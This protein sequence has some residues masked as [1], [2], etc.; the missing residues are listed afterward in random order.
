ML[1]SKLNNLKSKDKEENNFE[2]Q[3]KKE[4]NINNNTNIK[5]NEL[6]EISYEKFDENILQE[7]KKQQMEF[8]NDQNKYINSSRKNSFISKI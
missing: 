2:V 3:S 7:I 4:E 1:E 6:P 5:S 8:C